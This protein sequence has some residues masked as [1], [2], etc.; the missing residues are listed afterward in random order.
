[1]Y[2][3]TME[4]MAVRLGASILHPAM[5]LW[6][7]GVDKSGLRCQGPE[8]RLVMVGEWVLAVT[9]PNALTEHLVQILPWVLI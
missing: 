2:P 6:L 5:G 3:Q 8:P 4:D 7:G 9:S 1:M